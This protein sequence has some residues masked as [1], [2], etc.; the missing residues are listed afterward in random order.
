MSISRVPRIVNITSRVLRILGILET[1]AFGVF[2]LAY[3]ILTINGDISLIIPI[4]LLILS[5]FLALASLISGGPKSYGIAIFL[6]LLFGTFF[7]VVTLSTIRL[8]A[9]QEDLFAIFFLYCIFFPLAMI[10]FGGKKA[11]IGAFITTLLIGLPAFTYSLTHIPSTFNANNLPILIFL[12]YPNHEIDNLG[13]YVSFMLLLGTILI[14]FKRGYKSGR[15]L[16][17]IFLPSFLISIFALSFSLIYVANAISYSLVLIILAFLTIITVFRRVIKGVPIN[18]ISSV[19][20]FIFSTLLIYAGYKPFLYL[21]THHISLLPLP[22]YFSPIPLAFLSLVGL[23]SPRMA[24]PSTL[25]DKLFN[26]LREGDYNSARHYISLLRTYNVSQND[27]FCRVLSKRDCNAILWMMESY[28]LKYD[29]C[30]RLLTNSVDCMISKNALPS[31][32][33]EILDALEVIDLESAEKL[34]GFILSKGTKDVRAEKAKKVISKLINQQPSSSPITNEKAPP[35]DQWKPDLW[36]NREIYGYLIQGVLGTGGTSYVLL[37]SRGNEKY[38]IKIPKLSSALR[39]AT[40]QSFTTFADLS[41]ESSNLQRMSESNS[42]IVRI[43][44][45]FIDMNII[46]SINLGDTIYYL[47]N[48]PAIVMELMEGG[49]LND[50]IK[51]GEIINSKYWNEIVKEIFIRIG[52]ALS[53]IH[54][55]GYVHLDIKPQNIFFDKPPG[56]LGEEVLNN[57]RNGQ[58]KVKLG[59]LGSAKKIGERFFEYTPDYCPIDQVR[60][61]LMGKG[62]N[63]SMDVYAF[64][65]SIYKALTGSSYNPPEVIKLMDSAIDRYLRG[66]PGFLYY[67]DQAEAI[68]KKYYGMLPT[69]IPDKYKKIIIMATNPEPSKRPTIDELLRM[70]AY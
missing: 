53:Y 3:I 50:L 21:I 57:I 35:L 43:Y 62:A 58:V 8:N 11:F 27:I 23:N 10:R 64:G 14:S 56:T 26:A 49:T 7:L 5:F 38:A 37:A 29:Y 32:T 22:I 28:D 34:A 51:R 12:N 52:Y 33:D 13:L 48:P 46:K 18:L 2:I 66:E 41:K 45:M 55:E 6:S 40:R 60:S 42:N 20:S 1:F 61:I 54:K 30:G 31:S 65:A 39:E 9:I 69:N 47:K 70:L 63:T 17:D 16:F 36:K 44:G 15:A 25:I 19:P 4:Y 67:L 59:D 24:D 68:Y